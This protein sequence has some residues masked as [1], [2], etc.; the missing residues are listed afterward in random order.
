MPSEDIIAKQFEFSK[1]SFTIVYAKSDKI[2]RQTTELKHQ[3]K[4][5]S[6]KSSSYMPCCD[7]EP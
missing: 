6:Y 4:S 3:Y 7:Q 5:S 1:Y 2:N